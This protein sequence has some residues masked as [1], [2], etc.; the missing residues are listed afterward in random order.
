MSREMSPDSPCVDLYF[1][2]LSEAMQRVPNEDSW[3]SGI[4]KDVALLESAL[5]PKDTQDSTGVSLRAARDTMS[6]YCHLFRKL[7]Q[8][9]LSSYLVLICLD[10]QSNWK[11]ERID[12]DSIKLRRVIDF[13]I[14]K[15]CIQWDSYL[16]SFSLIS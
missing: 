8:T 1:E 15:I 10:L 11:G 12:Y 5:S 4:L 13:T 7:A 3:L 14:A 2:F 16:L 9:P 6:F